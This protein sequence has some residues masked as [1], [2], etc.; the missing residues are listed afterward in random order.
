M[1]ANIMLPTNAKMAAFV[2]SGRMRPKFRYGGRFACHQASWSAA[3]APTSMA[4]RPQPTDAK[5]NLRETS[6]S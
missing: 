5:T 1:P 6:S 3:S 4:T 2:W